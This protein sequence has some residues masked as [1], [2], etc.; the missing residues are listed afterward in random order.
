MDVFDWI[1]GTAQGLRAE[2]VETY[3]I[4]LAVVVPIIVVLNL[5]K[6]AEGGFD[7]AE[8][9]KRVFVS[10]LMLSSFEEVSNVIAITTDGL[11][12]KFG[13]MDDLGA[14]YE[15]LKMRFSE[16]GPSLFSFRR[17]ALYGISVFCYI[18]AILG[19]YVADILINFSYTI[20]YVL[21]P[22]MI[23]AYVPKSTAHITAN[24]YKGMLHVS[25]WKVL[26]SLLGVLLLKLTSASETG[27][28]DGFLTTALV[29]LCI[30]VSMLA[31]PVFSGCLLGG[32]LESFVS[33]LASSAT[34]FSPNKILSLP[35][36]GTKG[37]GKETV[38]GF[39]G[40]RRFVGRRAKAFQKRAE[41]H[42]RARLKKRVEDLK[43]RGIQGRT[44][45]ISQ[46]KPKKRS[47]E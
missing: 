19:Y 45:K 33:G 41:R 27:G 8:L 11:A 34:P 26:W 23:L 16:D 4:L 13:G 17:M 31:I 39:R 3:W 9:L 25:S 30:G 6:S 21:S 1:P 24:L 38:S 42:K 32:G 12:D 37:F 20:L 28:W 36:R 44:K 47:K 22:L 2:M 10:V 5:L 35:G 40:T 46:T 18:V 14:L 29:N 15:A 43:K 7:P